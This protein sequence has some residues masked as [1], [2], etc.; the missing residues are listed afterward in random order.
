MQFCLV[1]MNSNK[2]TT[3][4]VLIGWAGLSPLV[5]RQNQ[6]FP[7]VIDS[8]GVNIW[9]TVQEAESSV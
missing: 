5:E 7:A 8:D 6:G 3:C 9:G 4:V 1:G 2:D